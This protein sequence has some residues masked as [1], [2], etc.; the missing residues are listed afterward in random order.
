MSDATKQ[1]AERKTVTRSE[2]SAGNRDATSPRTVRW[3]PAPRKRPV[4]LSSLAILY[5]V[6]LGVLGWIAANAI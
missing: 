3:L 4:L 2:T 6:W 5:A 1:P